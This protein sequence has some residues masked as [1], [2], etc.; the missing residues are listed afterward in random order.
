[1]KR[2][3]MLFAIATVLLPYGCAP[4][5]GPVFAK[6]FVKQP[7]FDAAGLR[8][9][10]N[11]E[12]QRTASTG[13][14]SSYTP[15]E[16]PKP[17]IPGDISLRTPWGRMYRGS[18]S[19]ELAVRHVPESGSVEHGVTGSI[20]RPTP[21]AQPGHT[22]TGVLA[23]QIDWKASGVDPLGVL[24]AAKLGNGWL[25]FSKDG[26]VNVPL[27]LSNDEIRSMLTVISAASGGSAAGDDAG[28]ADEHAAL[29]AKLSNDS[30]PS[31]ANRIILSIT[32]EGPDPAYKVV[33]Q[34]RSSA[35]AIHGIQFDFGHIN[36]GE[37][38]NRFSPIS[39]TSDTDDLNPMVFA[40]VTSSNAPSA[41]T[42]SRLRLTSVKRPRPVPLQLA[43]SS[44]DTDPVP[45]Q[46]LRVQCESTNPGDGPVRGVSF[47]VAVGKAAAAPA[48]GPA[49]FAAHAHVKFELNPTLP[50]SVPAG[51]SVPITITMNEPDAVP[52]QQQ[53]S[54]KVIES[55]GVCKQGKLTRDGYRSKRKKLQ[56]MLTAKTLTQDEFDKYDAEMVSCLEVV[57]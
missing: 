21:P 20:A 7:V 6:T 35:T 26:L 41:T 52:V 31:G 49:E 15:A 3:Y 47:Q 22:V 54:I 39:I 32:N 18:V 27:T 50:A 24:D 34:L 11:V 57:P 36:R 9:H 56:D 38:K 29:T 2:I 19:F 14:A 46:R 28:R 43:C 4:A 1:M 30:D 12:C 55:H 51:T 25:V 37:T 48:V 45:G 5:P 8:L 44:L 33:A 17:P 10:V 13:T 23:V 53:I 16:C 40:T 42:S